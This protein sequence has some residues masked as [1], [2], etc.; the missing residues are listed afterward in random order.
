MGVLLCMKYLMFAFNVLIF[1]GGICLLGVG[2]WVV[3]DPEGF[4]S[5]VTSNP[6]LS[7]GAF[8]LLIVGVFLALLGF[9]GCFG[10]IRESKILLM[11]FFVLILLLFT[12]ELVGAILALTYSKKI[13]R[14]FYLAELQMHYKGDNSSDVF[15]SSWN[16]I[17]IAFSCC[18]VS[19]AEDFGNASYF[20]EIYPST[21]WPDACC[22]RDL[23]MLTRKILDRERCIQGEAGYLNN[24]GCFSTIAKTL[25][26]YSSVTGAVGLSV[27]GI[28]IFAMFLSLCLYYNFD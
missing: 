3:A 15:S 5:I 13:N 14:E 19:R 9:L 7:T 10:A 24:Q 6:I 12:V 22:R 2:I 8:I 11:V 27:L 4:Q 20:H 18:G 25:K 16:T 1:V 28:E 21:P 26:R 17:M 23:S